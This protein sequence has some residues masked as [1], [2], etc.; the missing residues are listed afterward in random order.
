MYD[1]WKAEGTNGV[2]AAGGRPAVRAGVS[3]LADGGNAADAAAATVLALAVTDYGLTNIGGEAPLIIYDAAKREVK[4]LRGQGAA[5]RDPEAIQWYLK[6]GIP[7]NGDMKATP[8][9]GMVDLCVTALRL[10]GTMPFERAVS[11]TLT[12]LDAGG[13]DWH[14]PL[15]ATLRKLVEAELNAGGSRED[16]LVAARDRFYRGDIAET[17]CRWYEKEGSFL[18]REDLAAHE[19]QV[20]DP[21]SIEYR[22]YTVYKCGPWT[23]GPGLCQALR[24]LE[25]FDLKGMGHL[26][27]DYV[28]AAVEALKLAFADRDGYYADPDFVET[29]LDILLSDGYTEARRSMV[30]MKSA[31]TQ[32]RPADRSF[33]VGGTTT[34]VAADRWGNVVS[35]TP[36]ANR[37]YFVCGELGVAHGNRLRCLNTTPGHPN[38]IQPGKRPRLTLTPT[39]VAKDDRVVVAISVAG[40]DLQDQTTLNLLLDHVEFGMEPAEAMLVPRFQTAHHQNSFRSDT[41]REDT[42]VEA[43]RIVADREIVDTVGR[44]LERRGHLVKSAEKAVGV[45][46]MLCVDPGSGIVRAAGDPKTG[47]HAAAVP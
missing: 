14:A 40:G 6:N 35:V 12:L 45:P 8:V 29:P 33:L 28:H 16:G 27:A 22:G 41:K 20:R 13:D 32:F 44:E 39:L 15:A 30:D 24:I 25:G 1:D 3:M 31:S 4:T 18:R 7:W 10:Y 2:V 34:C 5:P 37:P 19:T 26:S 11:P 38:I 21:V 36:S 9:P 17:L 47:R 23:Q 42:I 43:G 46:V